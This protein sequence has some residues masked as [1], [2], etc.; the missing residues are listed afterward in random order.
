MTGSNT[1]VQSKLNSSMI[2]EDSDCSEG[3]SAA[4]SPVEEN[5]SEM[6]I[7]AS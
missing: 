5:R 3:S 1:V 7:Q 2:H 4:S 6:I